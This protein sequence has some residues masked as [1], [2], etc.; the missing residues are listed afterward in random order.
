MLLCECWSSH[1]LRP[2]LCKRGLSQRAC[3]E[4]HLQ[5]QRDGEAGL[6]R[7]L[8]EEGSTVGHA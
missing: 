7:L 6:L 4:H 5:V 2:L 8:A 3:V 1:T